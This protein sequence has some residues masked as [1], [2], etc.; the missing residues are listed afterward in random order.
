MCRAIDG[1]Y[2]ATLIKAHFKH[3]P[4]LYEITCSFF[5]LLVFFLMMCCVL[6]HPVSNLFSEEGFLRA[7]GD[8]FRIG[9]RHRCGTSGGTSALEECKLVK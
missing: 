2:T 8:Q 1:R 7:Q 6:K 3:P 5:L 4:T 9:T